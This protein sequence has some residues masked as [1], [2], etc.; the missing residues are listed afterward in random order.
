MLPSR[1]AKYLALLKLI[2]YPF[3]MQENQGLVSGMW[4]NARLRADLL[5]GLTCWLQPLLGLHNVTS[6]SACSVYICPEVTSASHN[7]HITCLGIQP[8]FV[9]QLVNASKIRCFCCV[10]RHLSAMRGLCRRH[11]VRGL[12]KLAQ[13][14]LPQASL[15][16]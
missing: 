15:A 2:P 1:T 4:M 5:Q 7:E 9:G 14:K 13:T 8:L 16:S 3:V 11:L 6:W 10:R 12:I